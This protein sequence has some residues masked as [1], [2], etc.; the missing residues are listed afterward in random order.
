[1][2][3]LI[4]WPRKLRALLSFHRSEF[5]NFSFLSNILQ[6]FIANSV[7]FAV[8]D[9]VHSDFD[10]NSSEI[11]RIFRNFCTEWHE[12]PENFKFWRIRSTGVAKKSQNISEKSLIFRSGGYRIVFSR[13]RGHFQN[14]WDGP[15]TRVDDHLRKSGATVPVV[16]AAKTSAQSLPQ[17]TSARSLQWNPF[18]NSFRLYGCSRSTRGS[19]RGSYSAIAA[20]I[21]CTSCGRSTWPRRKPKLQRNKCAS[22]A[23]VPTYVVVNFFRHLTNFRRSVLGFIDSQDGESTRIEIFSRST[24]CQFLCT[25]SN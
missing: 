21:K 12:I 3:T 5:R 18:W 14:L 24:R 6:L 25:A 4:W 13:F 11:S 10:E 16:V 7:N 23:S 19:T 20:V 8:F 17:K 22:E 9:S 15:V 2:Y 1:M